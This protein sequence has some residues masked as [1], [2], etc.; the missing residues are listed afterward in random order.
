MSVEAAGLLHPG[1]VHGRTSTSSIRDRP[2]NVRPNIYAGCMTNAKPRATFR[3]NDRLRA[4]ARQEGMSRSQEEPPPS[5]NRNRHGRGLR[6]PLLN[7][8]LPGW[9]TRREEFAELVSDVVDEYQQRLS[10]ISEIQ[11]GVEEVAPSAPAE[12]ESHDV[13]QARA[14]PKDRVRGLPAR[15]VLYRLAIQAHHRP[16]Q[17]E[18]AVY[19]L[20]AQRIAEITGTDP[21]SLMG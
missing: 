5:R 13:T 17:L 2:G 16:D 11:I 18:L 15:I 4:I 12:W 19:T 14:F 21:D 3:S 1:L 6:G 10:E 9:R 20:L 7:P 8:A